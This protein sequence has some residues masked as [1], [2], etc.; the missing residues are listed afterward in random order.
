MRI[1]VDDNPLCLAYFSKCL[2]STSFEKP[3][4]TSPQ[5]PRPAWSP[6]P[7]LWNH[8]SAL[9]SRTDYPV[10]HACWSPCPSF[11]WQPPGGRDRTSHHCTFRAWQGALSKNMSEK[12]SQRTLPSPFSACPSLHDVNWWQR[13]KLNRFNMSPNTTHFTMEFLSGIIWEE[14]ILSFLYLMRL[15]WPFHLLQPQGPEPGSL[16]I[17]CE[18]WEHR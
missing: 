13:H 5:A 17:Y 2:I 6:C 4:V 12:Y 16:F 8:L 9:L 15:Q 18:V 1:Q 10:I 7:G 3:S 14:R 11:R